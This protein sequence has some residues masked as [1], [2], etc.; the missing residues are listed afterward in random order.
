MNVEIWA[1]IACPWCYLGLHRF[2]TA[3]AGFEHR[4]EVTVRWRSFELDPS[5]PREPGVDTATHLAAKDGMTRDEAVASQR[6]LTDIAAADGLQVRLD[7]ARI[8]STFDAHRLVHLASEHGRSEAVAERLM[9]AY[10]A[11]GEPVSDPVTLTRLAAEA[12]LPAEEVDELLAGER[13]AADVR[14]DERL[15]ETLG[16]G[17]VPFF[18]ADRTFAASGAQSPAVLGELL[19]RAFAAAPA[20]RVSR[21]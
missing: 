1:D 7:L 12:G 21:D 3:L 6:R 9:R 13:F 8:G 18:V 10:H 17:G 16:I 19:R 15:A 2:E 5:A 20:A 14:E 4:D 11:E